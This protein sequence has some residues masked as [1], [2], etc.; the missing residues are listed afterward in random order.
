MD[1][2]IPDTKKTDPASK[3]ANRRLRRSVGTR[4]IALIA[5]MIAATGVQCTL[6]TDDCRKERDDAT[7]CS[8]VALDTARQCTST[9]NANNQSSAGCGAPILGA[10][11]ICPLAVSDVCE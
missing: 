6:G 9:A 11:L 4:H 10:L 1:R 3:N 7:L 5:L 8:L 2:N